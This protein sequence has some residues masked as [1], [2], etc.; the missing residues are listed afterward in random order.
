VTTSVAS[1]TDICAIRIRG[2]YE[3]RN[4]M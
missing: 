2:L 4:V 1:R 3:M